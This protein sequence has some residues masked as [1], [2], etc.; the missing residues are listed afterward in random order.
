[1]RQPTPARTTR[2]LTPIRWHPALA[3]LLAAAV[4]A[5]SSDAPFSQ[6]PGFD[7]WYTA[8]P[9]DPAPATRAERDLL[10]KYRPV[11]HVPADAPGPLAFYRDYIG[12]GRLQSPD[13]TWEQVDRS[14]LVRH[15]DEPRAVFEH[16][17][18]AEPDPRP[19]AYGRVEHGWLAPFGRLTFVQW[20]FV[21]RESGLPADLPVWQSLL[22]NVFAD[23]SDWHQLDHYTA[24]TLVLGPGEEPLGVILQQ[25]NALRSYWFGRD[26]PAP[27]DGRIELAA[28]KRSNELYPWAPAERR[29]RVVRFLE[30]GNVRWLATGD[31]D[32][33]W[34]A[35]TDV[36]VPGERVDYALRYL[37]STDPFY[38]FAGRLGSERLL[39]GRS[40]PPGADYNTLP[41]F[42]SRVDQFCWLRWHD[43][44]DEARLSALEALLADPR[45]GDARGTLRRTCRA[46]V[47]Q[48]IGYNAPL[49]DE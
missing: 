28:A 41:P 7:A 4:S 22:A 32:K 26:W 24:A 15:A 16:D 46:F 14:R 13:G 18:P 35:S 8:H 6:Y 42:K 45:D 5:C 33:P 44:V 25:H 30:A 21:F 36:T 2:Q 29:H 11:L 34:T 37:P 40:G 47:A 43:H 23:P 3:A 12:H 19:V 9:P 39:P 10:R 31:G 38:R 27:S 20:H 48:A 1:L 49:E 17:P